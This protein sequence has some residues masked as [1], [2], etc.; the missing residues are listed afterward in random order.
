MEFKDYY[1]ILGVAKT[2]S[3]DEI[4]KAFR[5]L[6]RQYHPDRAG[7]TSQNEARFKE[8]GEAYE[9]LSN[10]EKRKRYDALASQGWGGGQQQQ[11]GGRPFRARGMKEDEGGPEVWQFSDFGQD[12]GMRFEGTGFSDFFEHFF[13][14]RTGPL[15]PEE[16]FQGEQGQRKRGSAGASV[17]SR[18]RN[19]ETEFFVTLEEAVNGSVRQISVRRI[20]P[21]TGE[22]SEEKLRVKIP[23]GVGAGQTI[24]VPGKGG[25]GLNG[26]PVG[27]LLLVVR[28]EP[29]PDF[30]VEGRDLLFELNLMPWE[31]ALGC[32]KNVPTIDGRHL[33]VKIPPQ[34]QPESRLRL[35]GLGLGASEKG[36]L[37][38]I[39]KMK[40]PHAET[41]SQ[42]EAWNALAAAYL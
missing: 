12:D 40:I 14:T 30:E 2:A 4:K 31:L 35:K 18:G 19:I 8:I 42:K 16:Y 29:H 9:V 23:P 32:K 17:V 36:N 3:L 5:D 24:R 37:Y 6:A 15:G 33:A 34:S 20:D 10:V 11:Y 7:N 22:S 38:V 41:S 25:A 21:G 13:G 26:G 39:L 27:D 1:K 28:L